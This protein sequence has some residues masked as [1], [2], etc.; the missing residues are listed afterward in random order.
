M[1]QRKYNEK[2]KK[3]YECLLNEGTC[4]EEYFGPKK[5]RMR[6]VRYRYSD[7]GETT[8]EGYSDGG[9]PSTDR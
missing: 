4:I 2:Y 5:E 7:G 8:E 6:G 3:C 1:P 9:I